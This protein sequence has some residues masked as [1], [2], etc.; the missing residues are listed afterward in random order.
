MW[1]KT[2]HCSCESHKT[3]RTLFL[4][5]LLKFTKIKDN[6]FSWTESCSRERRPTSGRRVVSVCRHFRL[7]VRWHFGVGSHCS[8]AETT[9]RFPGRFARIRSALWN[10]ESYFN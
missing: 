9:D 4:G 8:K 6:T 3:T 7:R 2:I 1:T 5:F 10:E